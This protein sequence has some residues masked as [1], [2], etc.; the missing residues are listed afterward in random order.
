MTSILM[1]R[2][3]RKE[4][5]GSMNKIFVAIISARTGIILLTGCRSAAPV[6]DASDPMKLAYEH[7]LTHWQ[8]AAQGESRRG[9]NI[10]AVLVSP[11]GKILAKELNSV[12]AL[13]D[14]TQHAE[15]RLI[16]KY[17]AEHRCFNL[18]ECSVYTTLEPCAMCAAT[19]GMAGINHVYYGQSDPAFGKAAERLAQDTTAQNG[20]SPYPRVVHCELIES[21]L[22]KE[23]EAA[24]RKS[25][26]REITKWLATDEAKSIFLKY[27]TTSSCKLANKQ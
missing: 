18:R 13:Q 16:Q 11:E 26:I 17:L 25:G 12:I 6:A 8:S 1:T 7:V 15:M 21:P 24:F 19:M 9:Y 5:R 4:F 10:A 14:C 27:L 22:Q 3:M 20:F 2:L 23:L